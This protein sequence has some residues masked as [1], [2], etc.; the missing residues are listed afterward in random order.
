MSLVMGAQANSYKPG[1]ADAAEERRTTLRY[2]F[3]RL[4]TDRHFEEAMAGALAAHARKEIR[5]A[6][7]QFV[8]E[9]VRAAEQMKLRERAT[10]GQKHAIVVAPLS[11]TLPPVPSSGTA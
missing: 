10:A 1:E 9:I 6:D 2:R 5:D 4:L 3:A 8:I 11:S 7:L